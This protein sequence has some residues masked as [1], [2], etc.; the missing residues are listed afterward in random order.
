M[1]QA[2]FSDNLRTVHFA[3]SRIS[4][5][6]EENRFRPANY[7][8]LGWDYINGVWPK[9]LDEFN[10]WLC[11]IQDPSMR[12]II[13]CE[14]EVLGYYHGKRFWGI[15]NQRFLQNWAAWEE[16]EP[17][18][19]NKPRY[20]TGTPSALRSEK[21]CQEQLSINDSVSYSQWNRAGQLVPCLRPRIVHDGCVQFSGELDTETSIARHW[22]ILLQ[23]T[24]AVNEEMV[25]HF[26]DVAKKHQFYYGDFRR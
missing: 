17:E 18:P 11:A 1:S 21:N 24:H 19:W 5:I 8:F 23:L 7:S 10:H 3:V 16:I 12:A 20:D 13:D 9:L 4:I 15:A 25:L 2:V 14:L 26:V 6:C 22:D